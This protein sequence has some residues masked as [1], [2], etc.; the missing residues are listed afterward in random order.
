MSQDSSLTTNERELRSIISDSIAGVLS[1]FDLPGIQRTVVL[2]DKILNGGE[3]PGLK[4]EVA[5]LKPLI[6]KLDEHIERFGEFEGETIVERQAVHDD[7]RFLKAGLEGL[8]KSIEDKFETL[9]ER[10]KPFETMNTNFQKLYA[11]VA[12][13]GAV[14]GAVLVGL[15]WMVEHWETLRSWV[16]GH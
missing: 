13:L 2:H 15:A 12:I 5:L 16:R 9:S 4:E 10:I 11:G 6:K 3:R 1:A 7:L 8:S 14:G